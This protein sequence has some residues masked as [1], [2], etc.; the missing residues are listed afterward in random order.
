LGGI[1][2][3][4]NK[5]LRA[6]KAIDAGLTRLVIIVAFIIDVIGILK[7]GP[8][9]DDHSYPEGVEADFFN[10]TRT[11]KGLLYDF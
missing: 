10:L 3:L 7:S 6:G 9:L 8:T 4:V 5:F 1:G 11:K 2:L